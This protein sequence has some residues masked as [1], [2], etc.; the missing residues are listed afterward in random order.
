M[1]ILNSMRITTQMLLNNMLK[2][3]KELELEQETEHMDMGSMREQDS[4]KLSD[5][6]MVAMQLQCPNSKESSLLSG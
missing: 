4:N 3:I 2:E 6:S 1:L 5:L